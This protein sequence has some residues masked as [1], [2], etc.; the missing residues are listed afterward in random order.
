MKVAF[1]VPSLINKGPIVVVHNIV[2]Y[3]K[4]KVKLIDIYYFDEVSSTL[5]F[6][7]N[8]Y[9]ISKSQRINFDKYDIVH[10]HTL[11]ADIYVHKWRK[12]INKAKIVSTLHQDTFNSFSVRYNTIVSFV[13]THYWCYIQRHFD[14]IVSISNQLKDKYNR[15]LSNKITTIYNGCS[16]GFYN[17]NT[18]IQSLI[19]VYRKKG[20]KILGSYAY[21]TQGKGLSQ[22]IDI[23]NLLPDYV[24]VVIGEGPYLA[25][26]KKSVERLNIS[27]R[28]L[29]IPYIQAPY[30][31]L[32]F[33]DIYMMP[34]Y[35]EGFGLAMVEAALAKKSIVC[36]NIPSFHEIFTVNEVCFFDLDNSDS[37]IQSIKLAYVESDKRGE[38]AYHKANMFFTAEIMANNHLLYY[39]KILN[40]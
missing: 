15:L 12:K 16:I 32:Q 39:K 4:D 18:E 27:D 2:K 29:F 36:S 35:S 13:L 37:L 11:R 23:L 28:V 26:L 33:M 38:L 3:L 20:Y 34:S 24:F 40:K 5:K 10:S 19:L 22:V 31:Y 9:Q 17:V 7:C 8:V 21:I 30:S 25:E 1:I 6:D 14:G